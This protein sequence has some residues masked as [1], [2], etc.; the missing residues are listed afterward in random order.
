MVKSISLKKV[1]NN[2]CLGKIT[3]S[4]AA[5]LC[6]MNVWEFND[7]VKEKGSTWIKDNEF[8]ENDLNVNL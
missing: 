7:L 4:K 8:L 2:Y 3:L 6:G 1:I 5:E